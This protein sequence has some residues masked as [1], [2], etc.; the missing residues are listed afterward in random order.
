MTPFFPLAKGII[1]FIYVP[2]KLEHQDGSPQEWGKTCEGQFFEERQHEG[3][4]KSQKANLITYIC[5]QR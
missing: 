5:S 2:S 3:K 4:A 1:L